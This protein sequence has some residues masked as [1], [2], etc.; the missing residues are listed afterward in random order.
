MKEAK[1]SLFRRIFGVFY[2][3]TVVIGVLTCAFFAYLR[4]F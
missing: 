3:A 4:F 2:Y 1:R